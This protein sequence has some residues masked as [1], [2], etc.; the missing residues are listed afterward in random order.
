[1][2]LSEPDHELVVAE[3]GREP[4]AAEAALFENLWSE[5]CAYRSSRPCCRRS[6]A[7]ATKSSSVPATTRRSSRCP[8]RAPPTFRPPTATPTTTAISTSRSASRATTTPPSWTRSTG[9]PPGSAVSSA[10]PCRWAR[11]PSPCSTRCTSAASTASAR[12]TSSRASSRASPTTAT[13]SASPPS[14]AASPSTTGTR[15]T[16]S[17]TSPASVS[18]TK[19]RLVTAT[20]QEPGNKLMLVGNGT[21]RDGLGGASFASEDLAEDAETEDRPAV[22]VGDPYAEKRLIECNE[23]LVDENLVLSARDLGA[24]GLGGASSEAGREGRARRSARPRQRPPARTE[25][26]RDGDPARREP[27]A[28]V[29]RGRAGGRGA[30]RGARRAVRPRLLRHRRGDRRELRLRVRGRRKET[31]AARTTPTT[32]RP[33]SSSTWTPSTSPTVPR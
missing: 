25:H 10:T 23:A 1:M 18:R 11:T 16:P 17:S 5:H 12:G 33:R 14:A 27:G 13:V 32:R 21:G 30:R 8:S 2:S 15:G 28:D 31:R 26:E 24:A 7:R 19:D 3:L 20:A 6:R 9:Q 4:T 29:L 22:Q